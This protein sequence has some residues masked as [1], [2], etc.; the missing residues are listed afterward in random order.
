MTETLP[1]PPPHIQMIQ[2]ATGYW[3]SRIVYTAAKL[4]VADLLAS[5][6]R[7]SSEIAQATGTDPR[8]LHRMLRTL[9][10]FGVLTQHDDGRFALTELGGT[11]GP[12][13]RARLARRF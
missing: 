8:A 10:G 1:P 6:P 11:S 3:L 13:L 2:M 4:G 7:P 9:A 12:A 5:G